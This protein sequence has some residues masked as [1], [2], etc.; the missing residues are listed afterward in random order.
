MAE[1]RLDPLLKPASV[2]LLG[3]SERSGSPGQILASMVV[4][5]DYRGDIYLVNPRYSQLHGLP[6]YASLEALPHSVDH[7]VIA[8]A[9]EHLESALRESIEHGAKAATIYSSAV[10]QQDTEPPLKQR[11]ATM[12]SAAGIQLCGVNGK[13]F[14]N[15]EQQLFA[16][17][18]AR[19]KQI[20]RGGISYIAQSG[21]A[22]TALSH[23]GC[24][25]G[26]NLCVS[27]G[28]EM[29]TTV[30]DYMD[31]SLQQAD[32]RVI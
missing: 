2:A 7:V 5:S 17:I 28:D 10:L 25:L 6:C 32:T 23:N 12:A 27:S 18:F 1:H 11:L 9:N 19:P 31:W 22:F 16:G 13:G 20:V 26:F 3:V 4:E 14:Y 21:S 29:T 8:L 24:R 30:A 15:L